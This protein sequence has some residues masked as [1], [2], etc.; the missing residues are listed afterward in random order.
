MLH[1]TIVLSIAVAT[2]SLTTL[3]LNRTVSADNYKVSR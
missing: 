3:L 1:I 2:V